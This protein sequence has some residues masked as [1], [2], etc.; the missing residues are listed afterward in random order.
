[1]FAFILDLCSGIKRNNNNYYTYFSG[2]I[3]Y[4]LS[5]KCTHYKGENPLKAFKTKIVKYFISREISKFSTFPTC[6]AL[7]WGRDGRKTNITHKE[8]IFDIL[9]IKKKSLNN[10]KW[11]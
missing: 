4:Y 2:F 11:Y 8:L 1:M 6:A 10:F 9:D 3:F 5:I 7:A